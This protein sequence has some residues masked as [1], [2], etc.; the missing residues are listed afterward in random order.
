[1]DFLH[2]LRAKSG[3]MVFRRRYSEDLEREISE[4]LRV[5]EILRRKTMFLQLI[6]EVTGAINDASTV[7]EAMKACIQCVCKHIKWSVGH[8]YYA[9]PSPET[10]LMCKTLWHSA[11]A[12]EIQ[13]IRQAAGQ[14]TSI[15]LGVGLPGQ[16]FASG[17]P[18]W[19]SDVTRDPTFHRQELAKAIGARAALAL[20][21]LAGKEVVAVL[22]FFATEPLEPDEPL[23]DV[24]AQIGT[25][26]GRVIE[27]KRAAEALEKWISEVE[28]AN[29]E[30]EAFSYSV[31]HDLRAPLRA[32]DGYS[33]ILLEL[34]ASGLSEQAKEF[35]ERI[36][37]NAQ[38]MA[39]LIDDLL[40]FSRLGRQALRTQP[41]APADLVYQALADLRDELEGREVRVT[42][43]E[44]PLCQADPRLLRQVYANLLGNALKYTRTRRQAVVEVGYSSNSG[45]PGECVYFVRD[46]GVGFDMRYAD[47][48]F[49]GFQR[50]HRAE[51][52]E[53]T[54]IGL[55]TVK[56]IV[57]RHGGR[58]WAEASVNQGA[59]F[60]FTLPN[61]TAH[62]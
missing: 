49:G 31:S 4:R 19:I 36:R 3:F 21:V 6:Q 30:L 15:S 59:T 62:E 13:A 40:N 25:Q 2:R 42:I 20:P 5:E 8:V 24:M 35:L 9:Q 53:G 51:D 55:A 48:V 27:R 28:E 57:Q 29:R 18:A 1:M 14:S 54:G 23:L 17:R 52:Y 22:E 38:H 34:D 47:K 32:M 61:G 41:V 16:V 7:E 44:L 37:K 33:R 43:G 58:I 26:L 12:Q 11:I 39:Q 10:E 50:L 56:R 45:E 60:Y 46:N